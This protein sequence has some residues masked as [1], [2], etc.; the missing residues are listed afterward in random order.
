MAPHACCLKTHADGVADWQ[1]AGVESKLRELAQK[2]DLLLFEDRKLADIGATVADQV[3]L[4][5]GRW[6]DL[7]TAHA[8]AG[9]GVLAGIKAGLEK[10]GMDKAARGVLMVAQMSS[11]GADPK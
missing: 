6:A 9:E 5:A 10:A 3:R 11:S 8:V 2:H 1:R 7:V 4:G